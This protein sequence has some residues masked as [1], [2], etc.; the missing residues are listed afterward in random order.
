VSIPLSSSCINN[1]V[2][3][4]RYN[5]D[6]TPITASNK[7]SSQAAYDY[8]YSKVFPQEK[9]ARESQGWPAISPTMFTCWLRDTY[10]EN[11]LESFWNGAESFVYG[12]GDAVVS[13]I[14]GVC[15]I[16][17]HPIK[18]AEGLLFLY[19]AT[20]PVEY[21]A[22]SLLFAQLTQAAIQNC[23]NDFTEGDYNKKC[24]MIGRLV[25]EIALAIVS[26]KGMSAAAE[27]LRDTSWFTKVFG[28]IGKG[29][30][31][32]DEA[33]D[34][35]RAG[36]VIGTNPVRVSQLKQALGR[37]GLSVSKYDIQYESIILDLEGNPAYGK[38]IDIGLG[39]D[40]GRGATGKPLIYISDL[41]LSSMDEAVKTI[42]HEINHIETI[43][44]LG[45]N[46][47]EEIADAFGE[48]MLQIFKGRG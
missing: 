45:R 41:G 31:T 30:I 18:T 27:V 32:A 37:A 23:W 42:F 14:D 26:G 35:F 19:K 40:V 15:Y 22:E 39:T 21:P 7:E 3:P 25:G 47:S 33:I 13:A 46:S 6:N 1:T 12:M 34:I 10:G 11:W 36:K 5:Y 24:R 2:F 9:L 20:H 29:S 16:I 8:Y 48:K 28:E 17:Q 44:K 43:L 38:M 4:P